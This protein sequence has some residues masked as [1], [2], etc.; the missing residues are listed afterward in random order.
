LIALSRTF[1]RVI[2]RSRILPGPTASS[3][4]WGLPTLPLGRLT[5]A[6]D[7]PPRATKSAR[8]AMWWRRRYPAICF[9]VRRT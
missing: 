8:R 6:Y 4:I 7:V 3:L 5:A 2:A 9:M 1:A